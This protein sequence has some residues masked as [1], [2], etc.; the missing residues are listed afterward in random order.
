MGLVVLCTVEDQNMPHPDPSLAEKL[1]CILRNSDTEETL[2]TNELSPSC[3]KLTS[4][5]EFSLDRHLLCPGRARQNI[6][7]SSHT[8]LTL[9][10]LAHIACVSR[11]LCR[12]LSQMLVSKPPL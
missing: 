3:G 5:W 2:S 11:G 6:W 12:T 8:N 9:V 7:R 1:Y 10:D 4:L